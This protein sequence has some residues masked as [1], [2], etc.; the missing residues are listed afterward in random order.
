MRA[1]IVRA[2]PLGFPADSWLDNPE[3]RGAGATDAPTCCFVSKMGPIKVAPFVRG[4]TR[5]KEVVIAAKCS[6]TYGWEGLQS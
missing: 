4:V 3:G 1:L 2:N 6:V 5:M